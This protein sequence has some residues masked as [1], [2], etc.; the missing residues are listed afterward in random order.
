[1]GESTQGQGKQVEKKSVTSASE[2]AKGNSNA[3]GRVNT[4]TEGSTEKG[5]DAV[6]TPKGNEGEGKDKE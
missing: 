6:P 5:T 3:G 4:E 2:K 1:M